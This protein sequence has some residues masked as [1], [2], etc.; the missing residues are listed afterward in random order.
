MS[1]LHYNSFEKGFTDVVVTDT[2]SALEAI[3][4]VAENIGISDTSEELRLNNVNT[5]DGE[6]YYRFQQIYQNIPVYGRDVVLV[7]DSTG[8]ALYLTSNTIRINQSI[9]IDSAD[10]NVDDIKYAIAQYFKNEKDIET[11]SVF[12]PDYNS[13]NKVLY[14]DGANDIVIAYYTTAT[15]SFENNIGY[16]NVL[17][18]LC[19]KK[20]ISLS[21]VYDNIGQSVPLY[22]SHGN[23]VTGW[24]DDGTHYAYNNEHKISIFDFM[25]LYNENT[26][27]DCDFNLY[28][29]II[30]SD[31]EYF[32]DDC[33]DILS[34][35]CAFGDFFS[36][37][38][39]DGFESYHV[40][41]N[42]HSEADN[43]AA[44]GEGYRGIML[45]GSNYSIND[46]DVL[47]HEYTH[48]VSRKILNWKSQGQTKAINE[49]ISDIFGNLI[50][51]KLQGTTNPDWIMDEDHSGRTIRNCASPKEMGYAE[52]ITDDVSSNL[53]N[54]EGYGYCYSTVISHAA[55]L[56]WNG[57]DGNESKK[58]NPDLLAKLWYKA[59]WSMHSD[60]TFA[61]CANDVYCT[62]QRI[63]EFTPEQIECVYEALYGCSSE[64]SSTALEELR[65]NSDWV[66][67]KDY[68]I[69]KN[70]F[71]R[72][73]TI[74]LNGHNLY[75]KGNLT[76]SHSKINTNG[77]NLFVTLNLKGDDNGNILLNSDP[78]KQSNILILEQ[79]EI[80]E[81][82][83]DLN[84]L[85]F[86]VIEN[87]EFQNCT[88]KNS[89]QNSTSYGHFEI[90]GNCGFKQTTLEKNTNLI[91]KGN[92]QTNNHYSQLTVNEESRV[93]I[94]GNLTSTYDW[95]QN[96]I[97]KGY[98]LIHGDV[99]LAGGLSLE[100]PNAEF[101]VYGNV[102]SMRG[103][104]IYKGKCILHGDVNIFGVYKGNCVIELVGNQKQTVYNLDASNLVIKNP[105]QDGVFI[106]SKIYVTNSIDCQSAWIHNGKNIYLSG[107]IVLD[108][109]GDITLYNNSSITNYHYIYGDVDFLNTTL[110]ENAELVIE[111][112]AQ[113]QNHYCQLT[114]NE[115][116]RVE[117]LGNLSTTYDWGP[118]LINKGYMLIHGDVDLA[119]GLALES[120][121]AI[122]EVLGNVVKMRGRDIY[123]GKCILHGDV[124][125]FG[126]YQGNCIIE[127]A[128]NTKQTVYALEASNLRINNSSE[129]G[130]VI[131]SSINISKSL[132]NKS[133]KIINGKN[134][135]LSGNIVGDYLGDLTINN[136]SSITGKHTVTGNVDFIG[137]TLNEGTNL[138][139]KGNVQTTKQYC[140]LTVNE[141]ASIDI[142]GN[143]SSTYDW[144]QNV[145]IKGNM[146]IHGD[147]NLAAGI[148]LESDDAI[149]EVF[150]DVVFMQAKDTKKG[151]CIIH[152]NLATRGE[153]QNSSILELSG[154]K[155]QTVSF[156]KAATVII[157]N[158]SDEGIVFTR[159]I[160][161]TTL[162]NHNRNNFTLYNGGNKS[163][164]V[165]YDDDGLKD[166]VD[167]YPTVGNG[168][169]VNIQ[170]NSDTF[171][172]VSVNQINT[173]VG[174]E[175]SVSATPNYYYKFVKWTDE[176]G[177]QISTNNPYTFIA[178]GDKELVAVFAEKESIVTGHSLSLN[179]DIGV[180]YY[181]DVADEDANNGNV[182]VDFAWNV[183]GTEKTYSVTLSSDDKYDL[184][185]KASCLVPAAEMT[186]DITATVSIDGIALTNTDTYSVQKYAKAILNDDNNFRTLFIASENKKGRNG[187]Q[188]YN[189][190]ITLVQTM[191][192]YGTKAQVVF[193]RDTEH[194]ANEGTDY[195][196]D[197]TYPVTS[198]MIAVTE[199]NMD[200]DLSEYGLRYKG[201]TVVYLSETS[202]RHYY[203]VDD[204]DSFNKIKGSVTFDGVSVSYTEKDGAIYFEK[205][206][207]SASNLDTP[208]TLTI[209]DKSCKFA[210]NDY[211]RHCLES[212][213]V[214]DNTKALVKATYRYNVAANAFFEA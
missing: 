67:D 106:N 116:A 83:I 119:G 73:C 44:G 157:N 165:D 206:G 170:S 133:S 152:G 35:V 141:E 22:G 184:G 122:F 207:V 196:N 166:N 110:N 212:T 190:L 52:S 158:N 102:L 156:E 28:S 193:D 146:S 155:K 202:I 94:F 41:L 188:R 4:T 58:I 65:Q 159:D 61:Q 100:S 70:L 89:N 172:S 198:N 124:N 95:G 180:N 59:M 42:G 26:I 33:I 55:Y 183:E 107:N 204:W 177:N 34:N 2:N 111:G 80:K 121:N 17:F 62:A 92:A 178:R 39:D 112:N 134:I 143:L 56:M 66:L 16:Y 145:I 98:M 68:V 142:Y 10:F 182:K 194:P 139:I 126:V 60:E 27:T 76:L 51:A 43:A 93:E 123:K 201:S 57:I 9:E 75:V 161:V 118:N 154:D 105:S 173:N 30:S 160:N 181:L 191:L 115:G 40:A 120:N 21:D 169:T 150:G 189:D 147:V 46:I 31:T 87:C 53:I 164:F 162:F 199:E 214:S 37:L 14:S 91:I 77:G 213:K 15:I 50:E 84:N 179:G 211:I 209:K 128:G 64:I 144:G 174:V 12:I 49:G 97:N 11:E 72:T 38:G 1:N 163:S 186:Y 8:N 86:K 63:S 54:T 47:A 168:C 127:L 149:F 167:P 24:L 69:D 23:S 114:V 117:I 3:S 104:D 210:V 176:N 25:G 130:V 197:E 81:Y 187:E 171:G 192:D 131:N 135:N 48:S 148:T 45:I 185:Y 109:S 32:F 140:Q 132:E 90:R 7:T 136:N 74:D 175:V 137:T 205:K 78:S 79:A 195:F 103:R 18:D 6:S 13:E 153:F 36:I 125:I 138:I 96:L 88:I 20:I 208:Y 108:Y 101:E 82:S 71:V 203:Y 5:F 200:M 85:S 113:T 129:D 29:K 151:K 99:N 19:N